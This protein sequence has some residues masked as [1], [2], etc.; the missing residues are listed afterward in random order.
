MALSPNVEGLY[1][2]RFLTGL[3]IGASSVVTPAYLGE[4]APKEK[5]GSIVALYEVMLCVGMLMSG[6]VDF[7]LKVKTVAS[8]SAALLSAQTRMF[9]TDARITIFV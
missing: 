6:F 8:F 9:T 5:R 2:G 3:G 4:M 7:A 1:L